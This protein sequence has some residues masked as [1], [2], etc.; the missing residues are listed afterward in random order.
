M[1]TKERLEK[2]LNVKIDSVEEEDEKIKIQVP[3][4]KIGLVIGKGG[5]NILSAEKV[6]DKKIEV[7]KG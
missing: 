2:M 5:G 1:D 7:T 3:E 4:D 6:L